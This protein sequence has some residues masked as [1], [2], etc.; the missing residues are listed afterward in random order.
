MKNYHIPFLDLQKQYKKIRP[1]I[2]HAVQQVLN[3]QFFILGEE[4]SQFEQE[5]AQYLGMKYAVGVASGTD[6][7]FLALWALNIGKG[8]EGI[9]HT[10]G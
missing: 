1:E 6:G 4:L 8:D 10:N 7:L 9:T 3:R 2:N 5:F